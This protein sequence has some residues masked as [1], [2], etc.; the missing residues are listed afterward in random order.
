LTLKRNNA[1][2]AKIFRKMSDFSLNKH[3]NDQK[4]KKIGQKVICHTESPIMVPAPKRESSNL[5]RKKVLPP[6]NYL[7]C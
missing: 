2:D 4:G 7:S 3:Q 5:E 1:I 6:L